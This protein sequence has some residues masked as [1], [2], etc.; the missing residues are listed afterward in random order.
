MKKNTF[1]KSVQGMEVLDSRGNPTVEARVELMDGTVG[2][3]IAPSGASTGTYEA[4]ELRDG[5]LNYYN[6]KGVQKAVHG[7]NTLITDEL[8]AK[9]AADIYKIDGLLKNIDGTENKTNLGANALLAVSI[10]CAR[11]V[12]TAYELSLY[13][14]LGGVSADTLPM[15]MMN[16]LNGGAHAANMLDVQEFMII[17]KGAG[18]FHEGLRWCV[19]VYH[20]LGEIV[21]KKGLTSGVG[22]E[23]GYAPDI[24]DEKQA[25]EFILDAI[26][27]AGYSAGSD[28]VLALDVAA[29]E[30][31]T[32]EKDKYLMPKS[33]RKFSA[34]ELISY[35]KSFCTSYPVVSIEDPLGEEDWNNW[36]KLTAE[37]G[38]NSNKQN[39]DDLTGSKIQ[40]V[41]D[42]LFVTNTKRLKQGI[43][44]GA[45]NA[46]LIKPNQIGTVSET[47]EAIKLAKRK[48]YNTIASHRSGETE[49][50]FIS[51]LAVAFGTGQIKT[52]APARSE[53]AAKYNR[54][55]CIEAEL[56]NKAKFLKEF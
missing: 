35:W 11:A 1:I 27:G 28:V 16:I 51:D 21:K 40:I 20:K 44:I 30:W 25:A 49:D 52:G 42:D 34:D 46:I 8:T 39:N 23:G 2:I 33:K 17:P 5:E 32:S 38:C 31:K 19:E 48:G 43:D 26:E 56:G 55:L 6:G 22:D 4:H 36:R 41:G 18:S 15:P 50:T 29:G 12:S 45:A 3:G 37:I 9:D 7:I 10:A 14:Y 13:T 53:R 24:E 47:I 54:L